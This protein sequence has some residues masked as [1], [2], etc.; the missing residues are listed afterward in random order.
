MK[1]LTFLLLMIMPMI[2][3]GQ[4]AAGRD[5]QAEIPVAQSLVQAEAREQA[6]REV[7]NIRVV[8]DRSERKVR[9]YRGDEVISIESVAVGMAKYPT[10]T[11]SWKFYRVDLNPEWNPPKSNWAKGRK[12]AP[13]GHPENPMGRARLVFNMP[14]TIHGTDDF[15]SL[16]KAASHGSVRISND[17]VMD[18]AELLLR[19]GGSWGGDQWFQRMSANRVKEYEIKM[20][21][22]VPIDILE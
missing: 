19:A 8:V 21:Y 15:G 20:Q 9:V 10:P 17:V 14:Y 4:S 5:N 13:P 2:L 18:L 11:G 12:R 22:P 6:R 3:A 7:G 16:G 1:S